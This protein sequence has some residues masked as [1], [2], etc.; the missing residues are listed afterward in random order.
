MSVEEIEG[1]YCPSSDSVACLDS[2]DSL[3][4]DSFHSAAEDMLELEKKS[5]VS[6]KSSTTIELYQLTW[7]LNWRLLS[8]LRILKLLRML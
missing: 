7:S 4:D 2:S 8:L 3:L 6:T 1:S 5:F